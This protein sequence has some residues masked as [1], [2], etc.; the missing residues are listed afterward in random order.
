MRI[1]WQQFWTEK[2]LSPSQDLNPACHRSTTCATTAAMKKEMLDKISFVA[3][4]TWHQW[5]FFSRHEPLLERF[6]PKYFRGQFLVETLAEQS[7]A[8][9]EG[10]NYY[11]KKIVFRGEEPNV[12]S[13]N[14]GESSG[15]KPFWELLRQ[16]LFL[17]SL[18]LNPT[19]KRQTNFSQTSASSSR[20]LDLLTQLSL[21]LS[22]SL[23]L[24]LK[25]FA[26]C[27]FLKGTVSRKLSSRE[28]TSRG[29]EYFFKNLSSKR[30]FW[31]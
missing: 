27:H 15:E 12:G 18:S 25:I 9:A 1:D 5:L 7:L 8:F 23:S 10:W 2:S 6:T 17:S 29:K 11:W 14:D 31:L 20:S 3:F 16:R 30:I 26:F 21:S 28:K 24:F 22:L 4:R 19:H 13:T